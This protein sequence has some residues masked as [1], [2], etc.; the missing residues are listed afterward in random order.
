MTTAISKGSADQ[1]W[2]ILKM[3]VHPFLQENGKLITQFIFTLFFFAIGIWFLMHE[4][5]EIADVSHN[6]LRSQWQWVLGGICITII[7]ILLQGQMYVFSFASVHSRISLLDATVLFMK[8]NLVSVFLPA[9]GISS[10]A[11]FSGPVEKRGIKKS[12]IHFA[13]SIYAFSGILTVVIFGIPVLVYSIFKG[14]IGIS[15][16]M[17]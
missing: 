15:A 2:S 14:A 16:S 5:V 4:R 9:G 13:S 6:I 11:F 12:Q 7:Y 17:V 8:R 3:H 10:L 1:R